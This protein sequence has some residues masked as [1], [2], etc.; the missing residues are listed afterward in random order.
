MSEMKKPE[1]TPP[2]THQ[3]GNE[4]EVNWRSVWLHF[5]NHVVRIEETPDGLLKQTTRRKIN[6]Q[7][8]R[9][10]EGTA[11]HP[12]IDDKADPPYIVSG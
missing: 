11:N 4:Y 1:L 7:E 9:R 10:T 2:L 5:K 12:T 8:Q 6:G 3:V